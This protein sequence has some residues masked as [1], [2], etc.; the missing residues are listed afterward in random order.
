VK[1]WLSAARQINGIE[2]ELAGVYQ[3]AWNA[4]KP[5]L[6]IR[7]ISDIVGF[8]RS[9]DWTG[10]ACNTAAAF[11]LAILRYRPIVPRALQQPEVAKAEVTGTEDDELHQNHPVSVFISQP[12]KVLPVVKAETLYANLLELSYFPEYLYTVQTSCAKTGDVWKLLKIETDDPPGD[13]VLK[14]DTL[15]SFHDFSDPIWK[16]ICD[17][18]NVE[19][20]YTSHW[21]E[22]RDQ[23]RKSEFIELLRNCLKEWGKLVGLKY[24][25]KQWVNNEKRKF[26]YLCYAPTPNLSDKKVIAKSLVQ[27]RGKRVFGAYFDKDTKAFLYYRHHAFRFEFVRFDDKWYL[28]IVPTYHYTWNGYRVINYYE[29]AVKKM[30]GMQKNG[31]VFLVVL[32][33]ARVLQNQTADSPNQ[34]EYSYLKFGEL[35]HFPFQYGVYDELW[36]NKEPIEKADK[37]IPRRK[38]PPARG[39]GRR[40]G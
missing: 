15:Y 4:Q 26:K 2:M 1:Q 28:E 6:A 31:A 5:V 23:N 40:R 33:W 18:N 22:S 8:K 39:R 7:G 38:R 35:L 13:W 20:H 11:M 19:E 24:I 25:Y 36:M 16:N 37:A 17:V 14:G 30:K 27:S 10:Y 32:F 29:D 34:Q 21:S 9:P 12:P 3:A